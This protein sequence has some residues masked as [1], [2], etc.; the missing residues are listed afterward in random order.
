[1]LTCLVPTYDTR[2]TRE[3]GVAGKCHSGRRISPVPEVTLATGPG[4]RG[5]PDNFPDPV[6]L[7]HAESGARS[8]PARLCHFTKMSHVV[9]STIVYF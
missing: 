9:L 1:M 6:S 3:D 7:C 4:S 2:R 8:R 5:L